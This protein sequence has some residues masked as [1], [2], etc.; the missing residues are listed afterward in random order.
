MERIR[1]G[2]ASSSP[3]QSLTGYPHRSYQEERQLRCCC[4]SQAATGSCSDAVLVEDIG[5][6]EHIVVGLLDIGSDLQPSMRKDWRAFVRSMEIRYRT[7][8]PPD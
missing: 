7:I 5:D 1:G 4:R 2:S 8:R 3:F 6:S